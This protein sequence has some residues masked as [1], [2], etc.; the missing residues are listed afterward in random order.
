M[1]TSRPARSSQRAQRTQ[2]IKFLT[3]DET[4]RLFGRV[5]D[6]RDRAIFL[7]AYR[8]G[9]RA[10]KIGLLRV[11]DVDFK[12]MR[13]MLHRHPPGLEKHP[14]VEQAIM[15]IIGKTP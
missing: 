12:R 3:L 6:K 8:H 1:R 7:I 4:R 15:L 10:T 11:S 2:T 9:L 5:T 14:V 13:I